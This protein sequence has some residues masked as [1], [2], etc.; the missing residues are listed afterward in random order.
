VLGWAYIQIGWAYFHE[1]GGGGLFSKESVIENMATLLFEQPLKFIAHGHI[2]E[3]LQYH[4]IMYLCTYRPIYA[5]STMSWH[6][7][8]ET[9]RS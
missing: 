5:T 2:F 6:S 8:A 1:L 7:G 9:M 4:I 3:S